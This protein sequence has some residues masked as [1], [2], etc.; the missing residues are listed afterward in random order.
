MKNKFVSLSDHTRTFSETLKLE[1][2]W[3]L[4]G[5]VL[6][7]ILASILLTGWPAGIIPN[8]SYPYTYKG[9]GLSHSWMAQ[10]AI[11]GWIFNNPRSGYPFGSSFLD[12]PGS[13]AGNLLILK[14]IGT[15]TGQYH[16]ALNIFVLLSFSGIFIASFCTLRFFGT[17]PILSFPASLLFAFVPFHFLRL[18]HLFYLWYF[19]VPI[20][21]YIGYSFYRSSE[22]HSNSTKRRQKYLSLLAVSIA[23]AS[24][25]AYYALFGTIVLATFTFATYI[26][27]GNIRSIKTLAATILFVISG[28]FVNT[29]PNI[30]S[31]IKNGKN[32]EVAVRE[33]SEGEIYGFKLMQLILPSSTH[34]EPRLAALT[35]RY[36]TEYPLINEN[37]TSTLG[38][39]GSIGFIGLFFILLASLSGRKIDSRLSLLAALT[40]VLFFFGTIGGFGAFFSAFISS[41]IRGWNRISIFISFATIA[42]FFIAIQIAISRLR[43]KKLKT[44]LLIG[45]AL[46][47]GGAGL[48]DQT[49][50]ACL[51]CNSETKMS[52]E[53]DQQFIAKIEQSLPQG[54][55]IYQLPYMPFPETPPLNRLH[56][57]DLSVGFLHSKELRWSYAG[58]KGREGDIF[59][60][61]LAQESIEKQLD[62]VRRI[63]FSGI[64]IDRRGFEDNAE[65]LIERLSALLGEGPLLQRA[66]GQVVFFKIPTLE[67][68]NTTG[69][70]DIEIM[71]K[72]EYI[73]D[74]LGARHSA[75]FSDGIDFT[76]HTWPE[77]LRDVQ[78]LS[79]LEPWGRWSDRNLSQSVI[80]KF[81]TSIPKEFTMILSAHPFSRNGEQP[82]TIRIGDKVHHATLQEGNPEIRLPVILDSDNIDTIEFIPDNPTSPFE[83]KISNDKRK[84][85]IGFVR[86]QFEK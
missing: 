9:D 10:R 2:R 8:L 43:S 42:A 24:F 75:N 39:I 69:L 37:S 72:A 17:L 58:M 3:W 71:K 18:G 1:W 44:P 81:T 62:V 35:N 4:P 68:S 36:N 84:L 11:E 23:L 70:S 21:F 76:R 82:I 5:M 61:S 63:G 41:S 56:T 31:N 51:T 34:R 27:T 54:S 50:P 29:S 25:G 79:N 48:Y 20:Y 15:I 38:V 73:V 13:D 26:K 66:D 53:R 40:V 86:L 47:F 78:G 7:F 14:I 32:T 30:A 6:S 77:F 85:A 45:C 33:A 16:S 46:L 64:Y 83:L 55:A 80:F 65:N 22:P 49:K 57:Y 52:F 28:V 74:K 60:R 19:V 59:Y 67:N 12:Y